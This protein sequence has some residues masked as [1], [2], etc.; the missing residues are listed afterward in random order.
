VNIQVL[1]GDPSDPSTIPA[2]PNILYSA[3]VA[4]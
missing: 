2:Q 4:V 1:A 3:T